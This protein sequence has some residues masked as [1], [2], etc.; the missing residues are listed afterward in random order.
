MYPT[1]RQ[2]PSETRRTAFDEITTE[3]DREGS[4]VWFVRLPDGPAVT[5]HFLQEGHP[6]PESGAFSTYNCLIPVDDTTNADFPTKGWHLY[7]HWELPLEEGWA[8]TANEKKKCTFSKSEYDKK[9]ALREAQQ[10]A[11]VGV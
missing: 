11:L 5:N 1:R 4:H 9:K 3:L 7:L 2:N 10:K 8:S 6:D